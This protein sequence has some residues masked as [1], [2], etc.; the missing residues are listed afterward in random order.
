MQTWQLEQDH[1]AF[2]CHLQHVWA[3]SVGEGNPR[4][5][6]QLRRPRSDRPSLITRRGEGPSERPAK[7]GV[8][9]GLLARRPPEKGLERAPAHSAGGGGEGRA[10]D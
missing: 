6:Q 9:A 3:T 1:V 8:R 2:Y 7:R 5:Q 10:L 4:Q